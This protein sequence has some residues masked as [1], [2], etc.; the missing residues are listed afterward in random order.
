MRYSRVQHEKF[1]DEELSA[2]SDKY[3]QIISK[4][5]S[6]LMES[7]EV[8]VSQF[9]KIDEYGSAILKIRN[10]RG[11]PRKGDYFCATLL[12]G[13]MS[14]FKNWGDISWADLRRRYQKEFSEVYC[15]WLGK[16]DDPDFSFV[17]IKGITL[18]FA[19]EL[20]PNCVVALGPQEPPIKY[21]QNLISI[22]RCEPTDS[23]VGQMLDFDRQ[24]VEWNPIKLPSKSST[25]DFFCNQLTLTDEIII[26]GPPGTGKTYKM[27]S[28]IANLPKSSRVLVTALTNRAL[29][30]LAKKD[31]LAKLVNDACVYKTGLTTDELRDVPKLQAIKG[32]DFHCAPGDVTLATFYAASN[33]IKKN[34]GHAPF[35]YV[36]MD[37]ASQ[38]FFVMVCAA[39]KLG[40]KIVWVGDQHQ[41]APVVNMNPNKL[42][43]KN[44]VSLSSGF[45]TLCENFSYPCYLLCDTYRL[46][47]RACAF[48]GIFYN[49]ALHSVA[50]KHSD[51]P[52][53]NLSPG[54]GPSLLMIPME[55]GNRS[56]KNMLDIVLKMVQSILICNCNLEV[57]I[58]SKFK[59][60]I[61]NIQRAFITHFGE[62]K[63][64]L[65]DTVERAQGLTCDV[66]F[67]CIPNDLQYMSLEKT[68]FNVATS[69]SRFNTIIVCDENILSTVNMDVE[70]RTFLECLKKD[71][72][73]THGNRIGL[74]HDTSR[75]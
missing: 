13:E 69:R 37:E 41:M 43:E 44:W 39:R 25:G 65:I 54:G 1:L 23:I 4:K 49:G 5:A 14:K 46:T 48:T 17:G 73:P 42:L 47:E 66:C 11:L 58:L 7:G 63:N 20:L 30:E 26:Q 9:L 40:K 12:I 27:A 50:D 60:T 2:I 15:A 38:G 34:V 67:F 3:I 72:I 57:A 32:S 24:I 16:T 29:I 18:E 52:I 64:V 71:S 70:V 33:W 21:Y 6:A 22:V 36:I 74:S 55:Q 28:L 8:F 10:S 45:K 59:G 61:K 56:P 75:S 35:D 53:E 51:L 19:N 68:F 62:Q 31:T